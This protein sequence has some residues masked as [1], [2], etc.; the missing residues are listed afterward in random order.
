M[1]DQ[2]AVLQQ[3]L[4]QI[5]SGTQAAEENIVRCPWPNAQV[6]QGG[7]RVNQPS[8]L[9]CQPLVGLLDVIAIVEDHLACQCCIGIDGPGFAQLFHLL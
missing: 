8:T 1:A 7:Q 5:V 6:R 3:R 9:F 2:D 4:L